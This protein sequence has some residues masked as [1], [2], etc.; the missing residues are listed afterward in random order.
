LLKLTLGLT[1]WLSAYHLALSVTTKPEQSLTYTVPSRGD[2]DAA[3]YRLGGTQ[4]GANG[5][6][7]NIGAT[8]GV[9][10]INTIDPQLQTIITN[11][12]LTQ[13]QFPFFIL[14]YEMMSDGPAN[15]SG[16]CCILGYHSATGS[17]GQTYGIGEYDVSTVFGFND[18]DT[19]SHEFEEWIFDPTVVNLTP[20]WGNVG[21]V[22]GC[23]DNL[24]VG[25]PLTGEM[26]GITMPNG[27]TYHPQELAFYW[28]FFTPTSGG[29][30]GVFSGNGTFLGSAK[31]CP[32]G[33]TN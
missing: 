29:V 13:N 33:G 1:R 28:W 26:P 3:E 18:I 6:N 7:P 16:N 31:A 21:Q 24:E 4:C 32:P 14:Y 9:V 8:L 30:N 12:G 20:P 11:L 19:M 17:P 5:S 22:G 15:N 27:V 10:N 25:D 2:S 23:Q